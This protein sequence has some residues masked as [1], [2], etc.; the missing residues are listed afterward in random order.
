[1]VPGSLLP[2]WPSPWLVGW[3]PGLGESGWEHTSHMLHTTVSLQRHLTSTYSHGREVIL[4]PTCYENSSLWV[5]SVVQ[6]SCA[7]RRS[8]LSLLTGT[9]S[10]HPPPWPPPLTLHPQCRPWSTWL[11]ALQCS[12]PAPAPDCI[13]ASPGSG[14]FSKC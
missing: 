13:S 14:T 6:C 11:G 5:S 12:G 8:S 1:M 3:M 4:P 9:W 7:P 10:A 2:K